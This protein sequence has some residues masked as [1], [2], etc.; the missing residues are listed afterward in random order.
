M[1]IL[2]DEETH[3]LCTFWVGGLLFGIEVVEV[4]EVIRHQEMT[5]VPLAPSVV[6]GLINLRGQIITGIDMRE[7]MGMP[8][9]SINQQ[10]MNVV[11]NHQGDAISLLVDEIGDVLELNSSLYEP[12]PETLDTTIRAL[13]RGIYK[14]EP[15]LLL[16]LNKEVA[17]KIH[18][19]KERKGKNQ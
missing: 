7:R 4:Q 10:P 19:D 3:Q 13:T 16:L 5:P 17:V 11:V 12:S 14:T 8:K 6:A 15:Q 1:T 9:R 18:S 2:H